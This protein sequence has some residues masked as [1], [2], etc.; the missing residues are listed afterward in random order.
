[1]EFDVYYYE[2]YAHTPAY[3][4]NPRCV[5]AQEDVF[6]FLT[7]ILEKEPYSLAV[8]D[9]LKAELLEQLIHI[10]VLRQQDGKI[11]F[12][13]PV[14]VEKDYENLQWLSRQAALTIVDALAL[15]W[16]SLRRLIGEI[17]NGFSDKVNLYH[18]LCG[19]IFDG[20]MFQF[21]EEEGAVTTSKMQP[22]GLDYLMILYEKSAKLQKYSNGLLCSYNRLATTKGVFSSFG[23]GDGNRRD[24]YRHLRR[25]ET[26]TLS[27]EEQG[28]RIP[29]REVLAMQYER[30]LDG[31]D[32]AQT[33]KEIFNY[34]G[35]AQNGVPSVPV[36][37][38]GA[39][40]VVE[41]MYEDILPDVKKPILAA[42]SGIQDCKELMANRHQVPVKDTA[43]ELY[44][45]IFGEVNEQLVRRG[46][47]ERP[48]YHEAGG[49]Y[50]QC[51][52]RA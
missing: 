34:F 23:D 47:V 4:E 32:V 51:Y 15:R 49:R 5:M 41:A 10:G 43:N 18:L 45:L 46:F 1:M 17:D 39:R 37:D 40:C 20:Y 2:N 29:D 33:Y 6:A 42:I 48:V 11:G 7:E 9:C 22:S 13:C 19:Q 26:G 8:E 27:A 50:L 36:Y 31:Y 21:L 12:G 25:A 28:I 44:H 30:L 38:K 16:G 52:E 3:S 35:Y 14:F 24:F